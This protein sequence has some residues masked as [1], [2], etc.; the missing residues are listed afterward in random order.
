VRAQQKQRKRVTTIWKRE[1]Y[2]ERKRKVRRILRKKDNEGLAARKKG[3]ESQA[4]S[5]EAENEWG[6]GVAQAEGRR[7]QKGTRVGRRCRTL[8]EILSERKRKEN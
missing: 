8:L 2:I 3:K 1:R 4:E 6:E 5:T 7:E